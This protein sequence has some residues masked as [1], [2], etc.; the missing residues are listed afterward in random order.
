MWSI[1]IIHLNLWLLS[2]QGTHH[3]LNFFF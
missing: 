2:K 3:K 1:T